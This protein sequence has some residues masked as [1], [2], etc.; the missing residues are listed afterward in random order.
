[1]KRLIWGL[2]DSLL[3]LSKPERVPCKVCER[4]GCY[5]RRVAHPARVLFPRPAPIL[6]CCLH[7]KVHSPW[8]D[9]EAFCHVAPLTSP[10]SPSPSINHMIHL[11]LLRHSPSFLPP[12]YCLLIL[13]YP[14]PNVLP[15]RSSLS[16]KGQV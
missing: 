14:F 6:Y 8:P 15:L 7:N 5:G 9:L 4:V 16:S 10:A 2:K 1:M 12:D 3:R 13:G 11:L